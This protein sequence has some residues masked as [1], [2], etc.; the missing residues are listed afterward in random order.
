MLPSLSLQSAQAQVSR[1]DL[2]AVQLN[3]RVAAT[4]LLL[5]LLVVV[6]QRAG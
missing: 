2:V 6:V 1:L 4:I 3:V 5:L